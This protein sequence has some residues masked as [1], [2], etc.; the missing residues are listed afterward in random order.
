MKKKSSGFNDLS[1]METQFILRPSG[2]L[3][4]LHLTLEAGSYPDQYEEHIT[5]AKGVSI[6]IRP[7]RPEDASLL[8]ELFESLSPRSVY[9]RFFTLM[10]RLP[11]SMLVGFTQIDYERHIALI[12]LSQSQPKGK[13]LGVARVILGQNHS[14]AEFS[15]VVSEPWQGKGIGAALLLRC[16]QIA[17][18]R[19]VQ[20]V[21]GIV[22]AEN[23]QMLSLGR[24][25]GFKIRKEQHA[26]EYELSID[27]GK[28]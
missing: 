4:P 21:T 13:M 20:K 16:L 2:T 5:T 15:V 7:I 23:T 28:N 22:L 18:G 14:A 27:F 6:F 3:T 10:K 1:A 26:P 19:G 17:K 25:L 9:L 8:V 11:D 12:A 24:K